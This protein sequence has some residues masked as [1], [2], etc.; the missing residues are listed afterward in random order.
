VGSITADFLFDPLVQ[1]AHRR[2]GG[3]VDIEQS[4]VD[5]GIEVFVAIESQV[6]PRRLTFGNGFSELLDPISPLRSRLTTE[7]GR[8]SPSTYQ[9][10][11]HAIPK[12]GYWSY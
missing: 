12:R 6:A 4:P 1:T 5:P 9:N 7:R 3:T 11:H 8:I 2:G 10:A